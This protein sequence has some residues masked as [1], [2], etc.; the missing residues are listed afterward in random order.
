MSDVRAE[1]AAEQ[2]IQGAN[3]SITLKDVFV[4]ADKMANH[5]VW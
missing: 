3:L 2:I 5:L 4:G 1:N